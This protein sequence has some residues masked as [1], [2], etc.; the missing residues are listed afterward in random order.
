MN[1][2]GMPQNVTYYYY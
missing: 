2:H 1:D